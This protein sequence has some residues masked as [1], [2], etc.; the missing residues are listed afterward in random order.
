MFD[1]FG[2]QKNFLLSSHFELKFKVRTQAEDYC[3]HFWGFP[4]KR[5]SEIKNKWH[6]CILIFSKETV[7][8]KITALAALWKK[9]DFKTHAF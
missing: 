4:E 8:L 9:L 6:I 3:T 5:K 7:K 1:F 2:A